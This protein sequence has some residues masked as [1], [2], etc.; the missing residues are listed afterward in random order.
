VAELEQLKKDVIANPTIFGL[1]VSPDLKAAL[2]KAQLNEADID[3]PKTFEA[4]QKVRESLSVPGHTI[5]S[6]ATRCSPAGVH[7]PQPDR[8]DPGLD[9]GPDHRAADRVLPALLRHRL[10]AAGIALSTIWGLG[11]MAVMGINLEPLSLPI[12]FLIAA[13][14]TSHGVQLVVRYYEELAVV[15]NG[16]KAARNA[17]DALF[18]PGS[19]P[20][21]S[22]RWGLPCWCW[23]CALQPQAGCGGGLLGF[24]GDLHGALHG[25]PGLTVLPAPKN[26]VNANEGVRNFLGAAM[27]R[28]GGTDG[29]ARSILL[30]TLI[31]AV[32]GLYFVGKVQLGESEPGSPLLHTHHDYNV[33]TKAINTR[34]PGSEELHVLMRTD[35]KGG[36]KRPEV[37]AAIERF[38]AHM[39]SDPTLG[40]AKA[41]PGVLRVVNK[42]T[43]N[44]D[45]AGC[46]CPTPPTRWAA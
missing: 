28:T 22:T 1:L 6:P 44:D 29:G 11:F 19:S 4:L 7:L 43:H 37:M 26:T 24:L 8:R 46:R 20:S 15:K 13:R 30:L 16:K 10:A 3:Y 32:G 36:I 27:A 2:I 34:F 21:S 25:A 39:L 23:G 38:Q 35:E 42:L 5:M 31:G 40:G 14:A 12:P 9:P 33:S 18:R 17:L 45:R 41:I